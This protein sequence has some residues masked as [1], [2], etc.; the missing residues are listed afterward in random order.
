MRITPRYS[1]RPLPSSGGEYS[2]CVP[3]RALRE[4][5]LLSLLSAIRLPAVTLPELMNDPK[6][7]PKRFASHFEE[8]RYEFHAEIQDPNDFLYFKKGDCDDY[9]ILADAVLQP[10][11]F[12]TRLIQV[13][14]AGQTDHAV[15]YVNQSHAYLDYNNRAVFFTLT[16]SGL[17]LREIA[18]EVADSLESNWT[19]AFEFTYAYN[20]GEK[21]ILATVVKTAPPENDPVPGQKTGRAVK[22]GF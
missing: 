16:R 22:V 15:C 8:F 1:A 7:S 10:K 20:R 6:L 4:F 5:L 18:T 9:A 12:E 11:G 13:K 19:S 17:T 21:E 3:P 2:V 14:L